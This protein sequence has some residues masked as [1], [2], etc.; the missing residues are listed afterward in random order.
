MQ[1]AFFRVRTTIPMFAVLFEGSDYYFR[2]QTTGTVN[3]TLSETLVGNLN[4]AVNGSLNGTLNETICL[5]WPRTFL[6]LADDFLGLADAESLR[7]K[8]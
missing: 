2:A 7:A 3:E 4:R 6:A 1:I 8:P 5:P